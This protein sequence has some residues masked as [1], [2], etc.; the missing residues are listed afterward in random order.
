MSSGVD[1]DRE[2]NSPKNV[3]FFIGSR[4]RDLYQFSHKY[5]MYYSTRYLATPWIFFRDRMPEYCVNLSNFVNDL[6]PIDMISKIFHIISTGIARV[7]LA[8]VGPV[9]FLSELSKLA[10]QRL[11]FFD[12]CIDD[13]LL[14]NRCLVACLAIFLSIR[15]LDV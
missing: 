2:S 15:T 5:V 3:K 14:H 11:N 10:S 6:I 8:T 7:I 13:H 12:L 1:P 4:S 9:C